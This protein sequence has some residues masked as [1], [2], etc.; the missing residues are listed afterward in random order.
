MYGET[1]HLN[2]INQ[3]GTAGNGSRDIDQRPPNSPGG[4]DGKGAV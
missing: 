3:A 2:A 4:K 1:T